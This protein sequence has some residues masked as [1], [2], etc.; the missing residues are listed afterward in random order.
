MIASRVMTE[1]ELHVKLEGLGYSRL[2][3]RTE[4]ATFWANGNNRVIQVP[5]SVQGYY[6][7]WLLW[8]LE[9]LLDCKLTLH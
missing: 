4:T 6:P 2:E 1:A 7:D 9:E 5:D 3:L 8:P